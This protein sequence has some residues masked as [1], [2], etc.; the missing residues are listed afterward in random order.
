MKA[1]SVAYTVAAAGL[2]VDALVLVKSISARRGSLAQVGTGAS[3]PK[4][5]QLVFMVTKGDS[6]EVSYGEDG[7]RMVKELAPQRLRLVKRGKLPTV[8][9]IG[10][11]NVG[12]STLVNRICDAGNEGGIVRDEPGVT[13]DRIYQAAEWCGR[14]FEVVDTGGLLFEDDPDALFVDEIRQ[15]ASIAIEQSCVAVLVCDGRAGR[16]RVDE[17]IASFLRRWPKV[18]GRVLPVVVAVNKCENVETEVSATADFWHLGLGEPLPCSAVH[19][20]GVAEVLDALLPALD[21]EVGGDRH[22]TSQGENSDEGSINVAIVGRP[23][24]GKS[25]L[26]NRFL[27]APRSIVS[28]VAGTTRDVVD[29]SLEV[30]GQIFRF[31]DTAGVRR[32]ARVKNKTEEAMVG[33]ALKAIRRAD[34]ALLVV[35]STV[36]PTDQDAALAQRINDDGRACV[37]LANKWDIK[38]DKTDKST[39]QVATVLRESLAP[40][41]WAEILFLSALTG[42]RCLKVYAAIDRAVQNHRKRTSTAILNQIV[43]EAMLWQP[44]P[45]APGKGNGKIYYVSQ[46]A[47]APPT[48]VAIC[49]DPRLFSSNYRRY[50]ERKVREALPLT[51]TPLRILFKGKRLRMEERDASKRR[52]R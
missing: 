39:R 40:V 23:N 37:V 8:A 31:V 26:L 48:V 32:K 1:V 9:V 43:R 2:V 10:R 28:A 25:S 6:A 49:N 46:T 24:V 30:D 29:E 45:A 34:V 36:E 22:G 4:K 35:D 50:L 11:P 21:A 15:Q 14:R 47:V 20:N 13:R 44:P 19:G 27:G 51:G 16:L 41:A 18:R 5:H 17:E 42:Q 52:I 7:G 38:P 33:R 3:S 12:K